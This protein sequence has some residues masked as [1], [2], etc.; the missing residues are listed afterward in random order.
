MIEIDRL[1]WSLVV[2]TFVDNLEQRAHWPWLER[3]VG[4]VDH[5]DRAV[6]A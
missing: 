2:Q 1:R 5:R 6:T 3:L 4:H